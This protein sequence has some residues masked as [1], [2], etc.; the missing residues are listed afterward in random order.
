[1]L[2]SILI[3]LSGIF[4]VICG[5]YI[6]MSKKGGVLIKIIRFVYGSSD[7]EE[8]IDKEFK[9]FIGSQFAFNGSIYILISSITVYFKMNF[10][11]SLILFG[12]AEYWSSKRIVKFMKS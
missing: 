7:N 6:S 10:L 3:L 9:N 12:V 4:E 11:I 8:I 5:C 1:M 2:I